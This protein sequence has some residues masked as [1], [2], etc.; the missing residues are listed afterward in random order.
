[1]GL[2]CVNALR[3]LAPRAGVVRKRRE[4]NLNTG[5]DC[6]AIQRGDSREQTRSTLKE[7]I[8]DLTVRRDAFFA[9]KH[10]YRGPRKYQKQLDQMIADATP[11]Q[12]AKFRELAIGG[13]LTN[14]SP[15]MLADC[16]SAHIDV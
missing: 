13:Q 15:K 6:V 11:E 3:R 2:I 5:A 1:M 9:L 4:E 16:L 12:L 8:C 14:T 7:I 10:A